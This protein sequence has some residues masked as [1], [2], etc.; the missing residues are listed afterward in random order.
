M[1]LVVFAIIIF[2]IVS[3]YKLLGKVAADGSVSSSGIKRE[4]SLKMQIEAE[5]FPRPTCSIL[6]RHYDALVLAEV[7]RRLF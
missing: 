3:M 6:K 5:L 1:E 7:E 2:I 4:D